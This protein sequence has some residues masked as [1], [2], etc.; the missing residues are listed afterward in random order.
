V[1]D[2]AL[3]KLAA[4]VDALARMLALIGTANLKMGERIVLLGRAGFDRNWI[5]D[6]CE[7]TPDTVSVRLSEAKRRSRK[8]LTHTPP[9][10]S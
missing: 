2:E 4:R 7:T 9:E 10:V 8:M 3:D 5:A 1:T 6:V